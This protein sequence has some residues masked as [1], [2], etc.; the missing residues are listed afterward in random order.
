LNQSP[1]L[2]TCDEKRREETRRDEK[3]REETEK[4]GEGK[5]EKTETKHR[6][7]V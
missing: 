3:R 2:N 5:E 1:G 7:D 6:K 4:S